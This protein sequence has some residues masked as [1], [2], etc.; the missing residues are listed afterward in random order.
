LID[1]V[2]G[3]GCVKNSNA[4]EIHDWMK[5]N[6]IATESDY[7]LSMGIDSVCLENKG[8]RQIKS[9]FVTIENFP[10]AT[11]A[12]KYK[13]MVSIGV[14]YTVIAGNKDL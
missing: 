13:R 10:G 3:D 2:N 8:T 11:Y 6:K 12:E 14:V 9:D 4:F 1:C 7:P 5:S